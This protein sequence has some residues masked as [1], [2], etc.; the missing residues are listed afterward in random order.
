M[1]T[2]EEVLADLREESAILRRAGHIGQADRDL[3]LAEQLTR[4]MPEYF[5]WLTEDQAATYTGRASDWL[6]ARYTAW[7][8]RG[9][10][11]SDGRHRSY[12]RCILEHRGNAEAARE[13][14]RRAVRRSA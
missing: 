12:R 7:E 11:K 9:L 5:T 6:R 3:A 10:A 14:G 4:A 2:P 8:A 1:N 13:A